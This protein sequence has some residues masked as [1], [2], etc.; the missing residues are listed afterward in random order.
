VS[1]LIASEPTQAIAPAGEPTLAWF[2][3]NSQPKHEH[4][5]ARHLRQMEGVEVVNPRI[6]FKRATRQGVVWVTEALFPSYL[7]AR[8]DWRASLTRVHYAPG[9]KGVVHFGT[10]WPTVPDQ[11]IEEIKALLGNDEIHEIPADLN[12]G[13]TVELVGGSTHG[14]QAVVQRVIPARQ[15]VVVLMD[16]LGRQTTVEVAMPNVVRPNIRR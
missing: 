15:R 4:I 13:D 6:R 9:V 8:F 14:L 2:C 1:N 7:F 10:R 12:P 5:A 16:F 3:I 11:T